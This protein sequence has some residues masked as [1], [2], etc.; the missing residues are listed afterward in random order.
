MLVYSK[1]FSTL[2]NY[3]LDIKNPFLIKKSVQVETH[4]KAVQNMYIVVL[5]RS[6]GIQISVFLS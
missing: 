4:Y 6:V 1:K 3:N 2:N 5:Q